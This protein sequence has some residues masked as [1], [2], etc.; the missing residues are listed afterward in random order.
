MRA[1]LSDTTVLSNFAHIER[2]S[3]LQALFS[4]LLVPA[5]VLQELARGEESGSIPRCRWDWLEVVVQTVSEEELAAQFRQH[6]GAGE[7]D[8]LAVA[9]SRGLLVLTDDRD[10]RRFGVSLGLEISGTLGCLLDLVQ[11]TIVDLPS[12]DLF[13]AHMRER[14]YRSPV[15]SLKELPR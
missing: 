5:S 7:S 2:P 11:R 10:A 6:L 15:R 14:G 8:G 12:A 4:P 3:L 13:L 9:H 1:A